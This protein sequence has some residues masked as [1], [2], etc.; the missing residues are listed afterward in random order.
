MATFISKKCDAKQYRAR[1]QNPGPDRNTQCK[2]R[3]ER[4]YRQ[5]EQDCSDPVY[6]SLNSLMLQLDQGRKGEDNYGNWCSEP[7]HPLPWQ[8]EIW[9]RLLKWFIE[10]FEQ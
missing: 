5:Y 9:Q 3:N 8:D 6:L 10:R 7:K 4:A 1:G 2:R